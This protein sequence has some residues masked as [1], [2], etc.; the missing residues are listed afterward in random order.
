MKFS[1]LDSTPLGL[2]RDDLRKTMAPFV[3]ADLPSRAPETRKAMSRARRQ[4]AR[5]VVRRATGW[6]RDQKLIEETY[7]E[8]WSAKS[9]SPYDPEAPQRR[10]DPWRFGDSMFLAPLGAGARARLHVLMRVI[11][12]RRPRTVLEV[13]SGNGINLLILAC[14]FPEISFTGV[15]LTEGGVAVAQAAQKEAELPPVLQRFSPEPPVDPTAHRRVDFR[16]GNAA[17]LPFEDDAFDMV[18]SSL[19]LEQMEEV[20]EQAIREVVRVSGRDVAMIEPFLDANDRGLRNAYAWAKRHFRGK[21]GDVVSAGVEP[22]VVTEDLPGKVTL[23][24]CLL[25]GQK[26]SAAVSRV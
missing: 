10:L 19:A 3:T 20:R 15:E 6:R 21:V 8:D 4:V 13:G 11:D 9:L 18:Y 5:F 25:L 2:S 23:Q 1:S 22:L 16:R 12:L 24:P 26:K 7:S 17:D 14:R